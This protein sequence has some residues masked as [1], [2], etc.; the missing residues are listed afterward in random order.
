[1]PF[2]CG[3]FSFLCIACFY[4]ITFSAYS[5]YIVKK[6]NSYRPTGQADW[7]AGV[8]NDAGTPAPQ[9]ACPTG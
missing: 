4:A 5:T 2:E 8:K 1:M 3:I 7:G 6:L 9:S